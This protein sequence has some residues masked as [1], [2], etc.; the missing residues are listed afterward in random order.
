MGEVNDVL[1]DYLRDNVRF[2]DLF[3]GAFFGGENVIRA[4][5]LFEGSEVSV[6]G[7]SREEAWE[8]AWP[9]RGGSGTGTGK[10]VLRTRDIKKWMRSGCELRILAA[11]NQDQVDYG[12]PWRG[13][14]YDA[15]QYEEQ[16][17]RL[18]RENMREERLGSSAERMCGLRREDRLVPVFTLCLYH[19]EEPWDGPRSLKDMMEFGRERERWERMFSDYRIHLLCLNE[20]RDFC[21]FKSPLKEL[22]GLVPYRKDK[23]GLKKY[24][25]ENAVYHSLDGETA[26]A[27]SVLIGMKNFE[28]NKKKYREGEGYDMCTALRELV[29]DGRLE[30]LEQGLEQGRS[31]GLEQGRSEGLEQGRSEGLEQGRSEGL[32]QGRNEG[33]E[34]GRSEGEKIGM[35]RC[36]LRALAMHMAPEEARAVAGISEEEARMALRLREEGIV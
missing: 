14:N 5:E 29:E 36:Y 23:Q 4:E 17:R 18:R 20:M 25:E 9:E 34:Q 11:E 22:F 10:T 35:Q 30:G 28:K 15:L 6:E 12:F 32:E 1:M 26:R 21:C 13:M 2:A 8:A 7:L 24:L 3:N 31:E 19:G 27:A 33:L 16:I